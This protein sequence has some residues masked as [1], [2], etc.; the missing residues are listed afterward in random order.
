MTLDDSIKVKSGS[1]RNDKEF[2]VKSLKFKPS[3]SIL[4]S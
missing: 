4:K 3:Q 2:W 1:K